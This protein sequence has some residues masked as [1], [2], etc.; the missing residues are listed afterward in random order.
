MRNPASKV[1]MVRYYT[2]K[3]RLLPQS[4]CSQK[5][6]INIIEM[7]YQVLQGVLLPYQCAVTADCGMRRGHVFN[8]KSEDSQAK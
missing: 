1:V 6:D 3:C 4:S 2:R 5:K 7:S 8:M